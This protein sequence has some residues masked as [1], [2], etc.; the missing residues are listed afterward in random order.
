MLDET[1]EDPW[2]KDIREIEGAI[3]EPIK[4]MTIRGLKKSNPGGCSFGCTGGQTGTPFL[5]LYASTRQLVPIAKPC[6]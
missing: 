1:D 2:I 6:E 3:G 4:G 5:E